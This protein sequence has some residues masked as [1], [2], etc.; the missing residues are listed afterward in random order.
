MSIYHVCELVHVL[1]FSVCLFIM[2]VYWCA[3]L[4]CLSIHYVCE[5][6][7]MPVLSIYHVCELVHMP[8]L[9]IYH[10][11]QLVHM[12]VHS[13]DGSLTSTFYSLTDEREIQAD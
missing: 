1:V 3:C 5:L 6:V 8:V 7:R 4:C 12:P 10:V 11:C 2:C 13:S 9:S